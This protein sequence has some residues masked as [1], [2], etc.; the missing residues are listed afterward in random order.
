[1]TNKRTKI[2]KKKCKKHKRRP[3]TAKEDEAIRGLVNE[4]GTKQWTLIAEYLKKK[5]NIIGRSG[6]Q[7]RERWHNH[8]NSGIVKRPWTLEEEQVLFN[9]HQKIGNKWA[10]ISQSIPGRTD[11]TVK[12]HFYSTARKYYRRIFGKEGT[13]M[14]IK[15]NLPQIT[16]CILKTLDSD[17][18]NTSSDEQISTEFVEQP[19]MFPDLSDMIVVAQT[20]RAPLDWA[21]SGKWI[22]F[23]PLYEKI[24]NVIDENHKAFFYPVPIFDNSMFFNIK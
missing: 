9:T 18:E 13:A 14:D 21:F 16:E 3:W 10:E 20:T 24:N 1:M 7:C 5:F 4:N 17:R 23:D 2:S 8:L 19:Q 11:N 15:D 12:N 22:M 6:K